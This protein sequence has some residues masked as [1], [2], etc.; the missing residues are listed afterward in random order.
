MQGACSEQSH[1]GGEFGV[2]G[3][4]LFLGRSDRPNREAAH[5]RY[6]TRTCRPEAPV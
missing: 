3:S 2:Q 5:V 1:V 6:L 4:G